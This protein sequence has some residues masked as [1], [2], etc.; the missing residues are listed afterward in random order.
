MRVYRKGM[1][2]PVRVGRQGEAKKL[3]GMPQGV[4]KGTAPWAPPFPG[5]HSS[6]DVFLMMLHGPTAGE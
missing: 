6:D 4:T 3:V 1:A 5:T 2:T